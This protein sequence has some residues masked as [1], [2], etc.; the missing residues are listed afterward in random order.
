MGGGA[1]LLF[2]V[3]AWTHRTMDCWNSAALSQVPILTCTSHFQKNMSPAFASE[4][5]A[6][7]P[8]LRMH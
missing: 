4:K 6:P 5:R 1:R 3:H 8:A 7:L 2:L